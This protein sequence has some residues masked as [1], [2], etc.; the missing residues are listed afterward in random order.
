MTGPSRSVAVVVPSQTG[1]GA[2]RV[3]RTL[4]G[5]FARA[6]AV[7]VVT[8]AP[9][10]GARALRRMP[11][12]PWAEQVPPGCR[13]VH[14]PSVGS[15]LARLAQLVPRVAEVARRERFDT[16]YSFLTWTNVLVAA[17]RPLAGGGFV[18]VASEHAL[19]R[20]LHS[21]GFR[22]GL[23]A[24]ALPVA[25]R[26]P[27]HL[28]VVSDAAR[29][30]LLEAGVLPRPERAVTIP[31]PVDGEAVR[32]LAADP[33]PWA[34]PGAPGRLVACVGR[35]HPQKDHRTL[36]RAMTLLP[37]S[38]GLVVVGEGPLRRDLEAAAGRLGLGDRVLF[39]GALSNPYPVM[40]RA[41]VVV[42]PSREEGFGLV[43]VEAA[44]LGVPFVGSDVGG[45]AEVCATLGQPTFPVGDAAALAGR[46]AAAV[47]GPRDADAGRERAERSFSAARVASRYL[48]L[49]ERDVAVTGRAGRV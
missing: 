2:E 13:H 38:Y 45:L 9:C 46:I 1:A 22:F 19:A 29:R 41:D 43:A 16:V 14:L 39:T 42:L 48:A 21:N 3:A 34:F 47:S 7:T 18:H 20:S 31:N 33:A 28:V 40:R 44:V 30:S 27:D 6:C 36:L 11:Q 10:V 37:P 17:A 8:M 35:L 15:G 26:A 23:L 5:E 4:A 12:P 49:G 25:Y 32:T 24:R